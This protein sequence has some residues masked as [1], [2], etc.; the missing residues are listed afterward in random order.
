MNQVRGFTAFR[1]T[2]HIW[3]SAVR[4]FWNP[5]NGPLVDAA[6]GVSSWGLDSVQ[7]NCG[8][9][10]LVPLCGSDNPHEV[11]CPVLTITS[12]SYVQSP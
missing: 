5:G 3:F 10:R 2:A 12:R 1:G 4:A 6:L 11:L 9:E 8:A 7:Q